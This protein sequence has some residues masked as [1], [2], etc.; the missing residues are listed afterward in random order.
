MAVFLRQVLLKNTRCS[1]CFLRVMANESK[2]VRL[3]KLLE[4]LISV[5]NIIEFNS[6][7]VMLE[8]IE[9]WGLYQA[10]QAKKDLTLGLNF[11]EHVRQ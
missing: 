4:N 3:A 6:S 8:Q 11:L 7:Q 1:N 2:S 10:D 9:L 5:A